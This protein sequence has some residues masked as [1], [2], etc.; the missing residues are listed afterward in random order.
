MALMA[1]LEA[2][3]AKLPWSGSVERRDE[4]IRASFDW[5]VRDF[6]P[7]AE[8]PGWQAGTS[9]LGE[10]A[11]GLTLQIYGR[12]LDAEREAGLH[13]PAA[14]E[15]EIG[16]QL[17]RVFGRSIEVLGGSGEFV[18]D[19]DGP[20]SLPELSEGINFLWHPWAIDCAARWLNRSTGNPLST[21]DRVAIQRLLGHLILNLGDDA[22]ARAT[23]GWTFTASETLYGLS[24]FL[25]ARPAG[26][27]DRGTAR[28]AP[29]HGADPGGPQ[30]PLSRTVS[31]PARADV[32]WP[33][34]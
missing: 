8:P 11:E 22:V 9:S 26:K 7:K 29:R 18:S 16:P 25:G 19:P 4:L 24:S 32:S 33:Y 14:I 17:A 23:R 6:K 28:I 31:T 20:G 3:R 34:H 30:T 2:R 10:S 12:L 13:I 21:L 1:L 5:L 15:Q 27:D